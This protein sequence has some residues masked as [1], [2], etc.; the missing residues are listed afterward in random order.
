MFQIHSAFDRNGKMAFTIP[1]ANDPSNQ[2]LYTEGGLTTE[3]FMTYSSLMSK[4][5]TMY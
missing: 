1:S 4:Q 3:Q 5:V 2:T